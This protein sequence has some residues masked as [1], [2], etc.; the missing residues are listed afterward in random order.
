MK[1][2]FNSWYLRMNTTKSVSTVFHLN[3]REAHRRLKINIDGTALPTEENPKY[4]GVTLD[5]QLTYKRHLEGVSR[6]IGKRNCIL[7]KLAGTTWGASQTLLR[8][9]SLALCYS[10]AE[11]CAP[12]WTRSAHTS[13][14]DVKLRDSMRIVTGCLKPTPVQWLTVMSAIAPPHL[15]REEMNR[16]WIERAQAEEITPL[17]KIFKQ[18]PSTS[19]LKSRSPFYLSKKLNYNTQEKWREEWNNKKPKGG[20]TC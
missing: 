5:R 6:K 17:Q 12:V 16:K 1:K 18:A 19:R 9:S 11:Y 4:L 14:V 10:V 20:R 3:N 13:L 7:R 2:Y 8:T 15:R